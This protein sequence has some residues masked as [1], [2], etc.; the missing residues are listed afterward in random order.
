MLFT[1]ETLLRRLSAT[2][3]D[4]SHRHTSGALNASPRLTSISSASCYREVRRP[5]CT[6]T[7]SMHATQVPFTARGTS[8]SSINPASSRQ[9]PQL[10]G[11]AKRASSRRDMLSQPRT[12]LS[13][14]HIG[15]R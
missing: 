14:S 10:P 15:Q 6:A 7:V 5:A 2:A 11:W 12:S 9:A 8:Q 4:R 3:L 1:L 13:S